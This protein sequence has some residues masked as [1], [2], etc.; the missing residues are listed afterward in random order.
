MAQLQGLLLLA[1]ASSSQLELR[2]QPN[3]VAVQTIFLEAENATVP[4]GSCWKPQIWSENYYSCTFLDIF[5][6]TF[7]SRKAFLGAPDRIPSTAACVATMTAEVTSPGLFA[8]LVRFEPLC[9]APACFETQFL[10]TI[11]QA[12]KARFR[13]VY[14]ALGSLDL[15]APASQGGAVIDHALTWQGTRDRV[16]LDAGAVEVSLTVS[17]ELTPPQLG[18]AECRPSRP[19]VQFHRPRPPDCPRR[20]RRQYAARRHAHPSRR[21]VPPRFQRG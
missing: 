3:M 12:G 17:K 1:L 14:G 20:E 15:D 8:P 6:S 21:C 13:S 11:S 5:G 4:A 7:L 10:L 16:L 18:A 19:D 2:T 9:R